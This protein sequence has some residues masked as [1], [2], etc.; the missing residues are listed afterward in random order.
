MARPGA[1]S[2]RYQ[3]LEAFKPVVEAVTEE[4]VGFDTY[5]EIVLVRGR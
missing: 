5:V 2:G 1:E 4:Q 3:R